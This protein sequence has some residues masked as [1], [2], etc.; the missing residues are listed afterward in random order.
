MN[1]QLPIRLLFAVLFCC[2]IT[3]SCIQEK[4]DNATHKG[5]NICNASAIIDTLSVRIP[6]S[7]G[8]GNFYMKDSII[9]YVDAMACTFFDISL[10]GKLLSRYFQKGKG[11]NEL[12]SVMFA[13][14]IKNDIHNRCFIIDNSNS[15]SLFNTKNRK[16]N[17]LG[18]LDF[19]WSN[20]K[21]NDYKSPSL[22]NIVEFTDLGVSFY[23][24]SDSIV[25]FPL[26]IYNRFTKSPDVITKKRYINGAILGE[27]NMNTMKVEE[28][29]GKYPE[30]YRQKPMPHLEFFDYIL[31]S[32]TLY[33]N[34]TVD[35]L[36]YVYKYPN[37]LLYC[38]GYEC[39][40]INR[41]YT[42]KSTIDF[43]VTFKEDLQKVGL[44][45]G[46][47]YCEENNT[48]CRTYFKSA[49]TGECGLQIYNNNN[50][51]ADVKVPNFFKLLGYRD[52]YYYG[53]CYKSEGIN[54]TLLLLYKIKIDINK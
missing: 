23:A 2:S 7:S 13:Y 39:L 31:V 38:I 54:E 47:L 17:H 35:S 48:L 33:V 21:H 6:E 14:D 5:V 53:I 19:G 25:L 27:L 46:I 22:Y 18:T 50:L 32:D 30:A 11:P 1:N 42:T 52:G 45:S 12:L 16:I 41:D 49:A 4:T 40:G 3:I 37:K 24:L 34:H 20:Q 26:S 10:K 43:N 36:I 51:I 15:V 44:N 29:K 8:T 9:T 28:V